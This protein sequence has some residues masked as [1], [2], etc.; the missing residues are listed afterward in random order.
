LLAGVVAPGL[1]GALAVALAP[2]PGPLLAKAPRPSLE[3]VDRRG[4]L[5]RLLPD[6]KAEGVRFSRVGPDALPPNLV[7]AVLAA[8]DRR[9]FAHPGVDPLAL[10]RAAWQDLRARH[11]VSGG[12]TLSMQLA[13]LLD[14][15]PRSW[16]AKLA[17]AAL[18]IRLEMVLSK[19]E[20][21][22]EYLSRVPLGNRVVGV[23]AGARVY[24][25]KPARQLSPA[26]AALLAAVPRSPARSN[27]WRNLEGL[28][29]RRNAILARMAAQGF[30]EKAALEA[31][32]AEPVLLSREPFRYEAPHF[33]DRVAGEV[34]EGRPGEVEVDSTLDAALQAR[35]EAAVHR[36]LDSLAGKGV[37]SIAVVV[38]DVT[39]SEWLALEGS[40]GF[41]EAPDGQLDGTRSPRQPGSALKPFTYATAFDAGVAPNTVLP[42]IP[43]SFTWSNGT[44]TPRN[45]DQRFHGPLTARSA[46][47]CSV[48]VPAAHVLQAVGPQA[49]LDT[50][51]RAGVTTL[52]SSAE[53]WGLGLTLGA[54]EVRLDELATAWAALLCGGVW[55][56]AFAWRAV[57][58]GRGQVARRPDHSP[59]RRVCS[60]EAAA[61][62]VDILAD[63]EARAPA[64]GVWSVLRLGFPAAVK[65]GTSEGFRDNWCLGGTLEVVVGV[66]AG[67]FDRSAMGNVSGVTGAGAV[68]REVMEAWAELAHPNED[69][70]N[71]PLPGA[72]QGLGRV[73]VC[74]LSGLQPGPSCPRVIPELLRPDQAPRQSCDWHVRDVAGR[75]EVRWPALFRAWAA[76][77]GVQAD[78]GV[79]ESVAALL[80]PAGT[81]GSSRKA[82]LAVLSPAS[83]DA[84][85][86]SPELPRRFQSVE[87]T[88][89]VPGSPTEVVWLVDGAEHARV[90]SPY[91]ARW[92]LSPGEHTVEV[93]ADGR[94]SRK[95]AFAVYGR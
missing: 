83:E 8:E 70:A 12:S 25:G 61:Q 55:R 81:S 85:V 10:V 86:L 71:A 77:E 41:W 1:L 44:W 3:V 87:L 92:E 68:W 75:V 58:D 6:A 46:L 74:A 26:E 5:L 29:A 32:L 79:P 95:V 94:R 89:S 59:S 43:A 88:C 91:S 80:P 21:L 51:S 73:E 2:S 53:R 16:G 72:V 24:L 9:F 11:I 37:R 28:R 47:A 40:G 4:G 66:W 33:L 50:L 52:G 90:P 64:F 27:P 31:A 20:I 84:F 34:G 30:L 22:A 49:L 45:Y 65:T 78:E 62:V 82:D 63:P 14:P 35:V 23:E 38:L 17:Q 15:R 36:Q 56:P 57:R 54:G 76:G 18:A 67:S 93:V 42:D 69:L 13:R 60:A 7:H 48:N 39:R 19:R